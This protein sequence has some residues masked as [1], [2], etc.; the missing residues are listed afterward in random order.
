MATATLP[1]PQ[2]SA[3]RTQYESWLIQARSA[4][5]DLVTGNRARVFVDQNGERLEYTAASASDLAAWIR[6]L[7]DALSTSLAAYR[8]PRPLRFTF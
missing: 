3:E 8:R 4:Y 7:E 1:S 6:V 2:T 5:N